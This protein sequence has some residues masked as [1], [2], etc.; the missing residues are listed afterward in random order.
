MPAFKACRSRHTHTICHF[1]SKYR[2]GS[3]PNQWTEWQ[4]RRWLTPNTH[5]TS[6][7]P[8]GAW[9]LG[10]TVWHWKKACI[11]AHCD[12]ELA[13][14]SSSSLEVVRELMVMFSSCWLMVCVHPVGYIIGINSG[15]AILGL[16]LHVSSTAQFICTTWSFTQLGSPKIAGPGVYAMYHWVWTWHIMPQWPVEV[17]SIRLSWAPSWGMGMP[18]QAMSLVEW[19]TG[20]VGATLHINAVW[21]QFLE[22]AKWHDTSADTSINLAT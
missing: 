17:Q 20:L 6:P 3:W 7:S 19:G 15:S 9:H 16:S 12:M 1:P 5:N 21:K 2:W 8:R 10:I 13:W 14:E 4:G 18:F 11:I 22:H